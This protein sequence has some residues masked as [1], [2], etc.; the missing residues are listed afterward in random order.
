M[1]FYDGD[2]DDNKNPPIVNPAQEEPGAMAG[3]YTPDPNLEIPGETKVDDS[4]LG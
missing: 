2:D 4:Q 3:D 1:H